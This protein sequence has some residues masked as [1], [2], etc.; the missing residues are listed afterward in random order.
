MTIMNAIRAAV[1]SAGRTG[2]G[3][4]S[5]GHSGVRG[6]SS[7]GG[8]VSRFWFTNRIDSG[9]QSERANANQWEN[10]AMP[11]S[12]TFRA[13][14]FAPERGNCVHVDEEKRRKA[15]G[16]REELF[17]FRVQFSRVGGAASGGHRGP[18]CTTWAGQLPKDTASRIC[19]NDSGL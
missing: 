17:R 9:I 12:P 10:P 8:R 5:E 13:G 7:E 4:G 1:R 15:R 16:F 3:G 19:S 11:R 14:V 2:G 6:R 18:R